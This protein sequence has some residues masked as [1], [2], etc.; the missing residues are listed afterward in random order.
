[1]QERR[2][3]RLGIQ[4]Q[5]RADPRDPDRVNDELL[6]G[7]ATLMGVVLAGEH[8]RR[9]DG[10][11][12]DRDQRVLGMLLDDREEVGEQLALARGQLSCR[13]GCCDGL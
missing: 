7:T 6:P 12:V 13:A 2:A 8:E 11:A 5:A 4:A 3:Q 1:M 10:L 9:A